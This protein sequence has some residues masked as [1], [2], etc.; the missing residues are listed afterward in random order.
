MGNGATRREMPA[1][2]PGK[3]FQDYATPGEFIRAVE[4]RFGKL[5]VDLAA[6]SGNAKAKVFLTPQD[7]ALSV[8]WSE[9][10]GQQRCWLNP[11]FAQIEPWAERCR[12]FRKNS[13]GGA[14]FFLTPASV[15]S[16][17]FAEH[18]HGTARVFALRGRLS[19]DGKAPY[20]KDTI[21]SVFWNQVRPGFEVWDWRGA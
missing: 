17:W 2:K 1:Q 14:I 3:S 8:D 13:R 18:I 20:P 4:A 7:D 10:F 5:Q 19:F 21:L 16:N 6:T 11:P 15:G 9:K 12:T